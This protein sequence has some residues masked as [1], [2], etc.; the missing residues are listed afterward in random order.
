MSQ[1]PLTNGSGIAV[2]EVVDA[3]PSIQ[4][5]AQFPTFLVLPPNGNATSVTTSENTTLGPISTV[6]T[7]TAGDPIPRFQQITP[8][9]DCSIIGDCGARYFP[10]LAVPE[11]SLTYAAQVGGG[12]QTNYV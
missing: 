12:S 1:V 5:S 11:T 2:Y 3:N 9:S 10:A 4:E 7:A 8:P 6:E